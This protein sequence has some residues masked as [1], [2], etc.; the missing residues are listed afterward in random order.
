[1]RTKELKKISCDFAHFGTLPEQYVNS[2][3]LSQTRDD[4]RYLRHKT[5]LYVLQFSFPRLLKQ[6]TRLDNSESC[7]LILGKE[8]NLPAQTKIPGQKSKTV[9]N[10][11]RYLLVFPLFPFSI[12]QCFCLLLLPMKTVIIE[13]LV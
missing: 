6:E 8:Q 7:C 5:L 13:S 1:M 12:L 4:L 3:S 11:K 9:V 2:P 10:L